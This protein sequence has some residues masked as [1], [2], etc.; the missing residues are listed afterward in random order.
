MAGESNQGGHAG[1][2]TTRPVEAVD[3]P[4]VDRIATD[5][6]YDGDRPGRSLGRDGRGWTANCDD[7]C[8]PMSEQFDC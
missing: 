8:C 2:I 3:E 1:D 4:D 7:H 6:E 5:R